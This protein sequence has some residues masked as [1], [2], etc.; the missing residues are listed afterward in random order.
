[1]LIN[2][3]VGAVVIG[4]NEG[5]RLRTCLES[6]SHNLSHIVY[7]D[8]GSIDESEELA[9]SRGVSV[10]PLDMSKPFSAARARNAGFKALLTD[11]PELKH[12]QFI[13]GDCQLFS[14]WLEIAVNF[15][16][17]HPEYAVACG[18]RR[19]RFPEQSVYNQL[20]DIEWDTPIGEA[21]ACGG[22][23]LIRVEAFM[24]VDGYRDDLI[25][26]EEPDMCFRM[27]ENGWKIYRLDAEMTWHDAAITQFRQ[28]WQ[29]S[30]RAGYAYA[31]GSYLHGNSDEKYWVKENR[32][33]LFWGGLLPIALLILGV[34]INPWF[35]LGSF[36]YPLQALKIAFL[37]PV[38]KNS[39][40]NSLLYGFFVMLAKFPQVA[41]LS[42]FALLKLLSQK[43]R[44]IEYK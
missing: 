26:G 7:V 30:K 5:E 17:Q 40:K 21:T 13:D 16:E 18:R 35:F 20:C 43:A 9:I 29:R 42:R 32:S 25:A 38:D 3:E 24:Q 34:T 23:A 14:G 19:E 8:S 6:L 28:W 15:L 11:Q 37:H 12:V 10:V 1:M 36:I 2:N 39:W 31:E 27:R 4:R 33:I 22:D 44:L 41:G